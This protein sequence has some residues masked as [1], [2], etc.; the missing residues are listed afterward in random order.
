MKDYILPQLP[1]YVLH[2]TLLIKSPIKYII[3]AH[4]FDTSIWDSNVI[5]IASYVVPAYVPTEYF[6]TNIAKIGGRFDTKEGDIGKT[7]QKI[8]NILIKKHEPWLNQWNTPKDIAYKALPLGRNPRD[9]NIDINIL[10]AVAY[11]QI[12]INQRDKA[13]YYLKQLEEQVELNYRNPIY[14][15]DNWPQR[16]LD[17]S[18]SIK[19]KL[20]ISVDEAKITLLE[21]RQYTLEKLKLTPYATDKL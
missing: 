13:L 21:W 6:G 15:S 2:N 12:L 8:S 16:L 11:S 20:L 4:D 18:I 19:N 7:F 5:K 3:Q 1:G 14:D 17:E 10:R 9:G